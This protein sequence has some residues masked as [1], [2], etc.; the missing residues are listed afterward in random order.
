MQLLE[1]LRSLDAT[2]DENWTADGAPIVAVVSKLVG[3]NLT[4]AMITEAAPKFSRESKELP[5]DNPDQASLPNLADTSPE[6]QAEVEKILNDDEPF[7]STEPEAEPNEPTELELAEFKVSE[8]N[9]A[10]VQS[11]RDSEAAKKL[12]GTITDALTV[13]EQARN[14]LIPN[15]GNQE[16]ITAYIRSQH[17]ERARRAGTQLEVLKGLDLAALDPRSKIDQ[18]MAR[19]TARGTARPVRGVVTE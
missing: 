14:D 2:V 7:K 16:A 6:E 5:G 19:K 3:Q 9:K 10:L 1:A 17:A 13:A 18:A 15:N 8:L 11:I 12:V 4:R